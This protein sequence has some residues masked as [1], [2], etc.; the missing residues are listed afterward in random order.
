MKKLFSTILVLGLLLSGNAY[1][2]T[3]GE[4]EKLRKE[5]LEAA[6]NDSQK[7]TSEKITNDWLK[8]K[9][10]NDLRKLNFYFQKE[11][12]VTTTEDSVQYHLYKTFN[13]PFVAV[14]IICFIDPKK[15]TCRLA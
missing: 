6:A 11:F 13:D 15:T 12:R 9:T 2:A 1:A 14:Y 7:L 3:I 10:V 4:L 8:N 5:K